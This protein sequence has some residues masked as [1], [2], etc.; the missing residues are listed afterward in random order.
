M[1]FKKITTWIVLADGARARVLRN[2]GPGTGLAELEEW[3]S[4]EARKPTRE[5][6]VERPGRVQESANAERHAMAP[7]EDWHEQEKTNFARDLARYLKKHGDDGDYDELILAAAPRA[8]GDLRKSLDQATAGRLK[9]EIN[10][11]LTQIPIAELDSHLS[12]VIRL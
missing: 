12:D 1:R 10:K 11:D 4:E 8:L 3:V 5:L 2:D 9:S 6:G 7:R